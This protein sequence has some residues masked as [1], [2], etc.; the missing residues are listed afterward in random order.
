[1]KGDE[2]EWLTPSDKFLTRIG[3]LSKQGYL[4][5]WIPYPN[6]RLQLR[7]IKDNI[8]CAREFSKEELETVNMDLYLYTL[9][10]LVEK[11]DNFKGE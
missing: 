2:R 4:I 1:M 10:R 5:K 11:I 8:T 9:E 3:L 6:N 7:V